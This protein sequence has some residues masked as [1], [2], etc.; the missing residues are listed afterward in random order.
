MS[1]N[2]LPVL[3]I[4]PGSLPPDVLVC[5]D[6]ARAKLIAEMLDDSRELS[7]N[8][9]YRLFTGTVK[10]IPLAVCS[11]G[12]G[13]AGAALCFEV[14][15]KAGAK[16]II[17]IGTAGSLNLD[18]TDGSLVIATAAIREEGTTPQLVPIS[19]PAVADMDITRALQGAAATFTGIKTYSGIV[20]TL[21]AFFPALLDLPNSLMSKANAKAVEMECA[22]LFIIASLRGVQAGSILAIDGMAIAF[23]ADAYNPHRD[24]VAA[25]IEAEA[26]IAIRAVEKLNGK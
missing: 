7:W 17:R 22:A 25:A 23:D 9:E 15:I 6:P 12:V 19:Y 5:G 4:A 16:R 26:R 13:A 2:L 21:S 10:G 1:E 8:R 11:H 20:L 24:L 18:I 14:L 3:N